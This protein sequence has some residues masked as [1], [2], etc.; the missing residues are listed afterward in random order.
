M[1]VQPSEFM[2]I[3]V[4]L[5][6]AAILNRYKHQRFSF[7]ESMIPTMN[8]ICW[9]AVPFFLILIQPDLGTAL[10]ILSIAFTLM[11]VSG[12][13]SKM[14]AALIA[15]FLALLA[16][17]TY[18]HN[19]HFEHFTKVIKPHQ[20]DRIYGWLSPDEF[21]ST[22]G[23]QLKQAMLGIGSGQLSG[24]GYTKGN[25]VQGEI[26]LKPIQILYL[27]SLARSLVLSAPPY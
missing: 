8:I 9:T 27:Q 21:D 19:E 13:S 16:F 23:Y 6:L 7:K 11:L 4:I 25:Q 14:I 5:L 24:S 2:K 26:S 10:V 17:L 1:K 22:Y 3:F 18:L 15:S 20:L 12:I